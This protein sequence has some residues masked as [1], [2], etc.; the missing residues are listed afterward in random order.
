ML[1]IIKI[2]DIKQK[3]ISPKLLYIN[4]GLIQII[5]IKQEKFDLT[6]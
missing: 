1:N 3:K 5:T 4:L 2:K 6:Y